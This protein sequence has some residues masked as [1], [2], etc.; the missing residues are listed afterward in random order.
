MRREGE[1]RRPAWMQTDDFTKVVAKLGDPPYSCRECGSMRDLEFDHIVPRAAGGGSEPDNIQVLCRAHNG[2]AGKSDRPDAY[3]GGRLL[4]DQVDPGRLREAQRTAGYLAAMSTVAREDWFARPFSAISGLVYVGAAVVGSGKTLM[5]IA[6]AGGINRVRLEKNGHAC[7]RIDRILCLAKEASLADQIARDL[8]NDPKQF[9]ILPASPRVRRVSSFADLLLASRDRSIEVVVSCVQTM[10]EKDNGRPDSD[11]REVL[12]RFPMIVLDEVHFGS[13]QG[14]G[15]VSLADQSVVFGMTGSPIGSEGEVMD[16]VVL[17]S[18]FDYQDAVRSDGALKYLPIKEEIDRDFSS[19]VETIK[20]EGAD[21]KRNGSRE[22]IASSSDSADYGKNLAPKQAV[23]RRVVDILRDFDQRPESGRAAN[24]RPVDVGVGLR[25]PAHA[26]VV[27]GSINEARQLCKHAEDLFDRNP[28]EYPRERGFRA[29]LAVTGTERIDSDHPWMRAKELWKKH[30][31]GRVDS[32]CARILFCVDMGRE[33][34]NNPFCTVVGVCSQFRSVIE[35]VQRLMGRSIRAV[36]ER[37]ESD[38]LG[39]RLVVPPAYLDTPKIVTHEAFDTGG[40]KTSLTIRRGMEFISDMRGHLSEITLLD[41]VIDGG[42][43]EPS[44][45]DGAGTLPIDRRIAIAGAIGE[46]NGSPDVGKI[47]ERFGRGDE[48]DTEAVKDWVR[49]VIN[50][51]AEAS[52]KIGLRETV[53][54][55]DLVINER[56]S[57]TPTE[58]DLVS[59]GSRRKSF[60]REKLGLDPDYRALAEEM[61]TEERMRIQQVPIRSVTNLEEIRKL[62]GEQA[63]DRVGALVPGEMTREARG[64]VKFYINTAIRMVL[65][66]DSLDGRA[67]LGTEHDSWQTH[68][69]LSNIQ[70][71]R[72]VVGYTVT[73]LVRDGYAPSLKYLLVADA[74]TA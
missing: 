11:R 51:P 26:M 60:S 56:Q 71:Q 16:G 73:C 50:D 55:R 52:K 68:G 27:C 58:D 8:T 12:A 14:G 59:F 20:I 30:R 64:R 49:Q 72:D 43:V 2:P 57:F 36:T 42:D 18:V 63:W 74:V 7:P 24:H 10:W 45:A 65:G 62:Y 23:V 44:S 29:E 9:G 70:V 69:L 25:F 3:W 67:G 31:D 37:I 38:L 13:D 39:W 5:P 48:G 41:D 34:I 32:E 61:W 15:I 4:F 53:A 46:T 19:I 40:V 22:S 1:I 35:S 54:K 33:G 66:L 47:L 28:F 17:F 21:I 6:I